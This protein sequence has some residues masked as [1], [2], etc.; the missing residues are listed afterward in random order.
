[1]TGWDERFPNL[2][3][4]CGGGPLNPETLAVFQR[5]MAEYELLMAELRVFFAPVSERCAGRDEDLQ[6][7]SSS[8]LSLGGI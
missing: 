1:V 2:T 6:K 8:S 3:A 7:E 4:A 5:A